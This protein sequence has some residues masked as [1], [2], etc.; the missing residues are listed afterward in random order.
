MERAADNMEKHENYKKQMGQLKKAMAS[1]FYLEAI[2]IEYAVIE[3]RIESVLRH[4]GK[5][6]PDK[7]KTL[8]KKLNRLSEMRR[9]KKSLANKYFPEELLDS[10]YNWKNDK[11]NPL[12]HALLKLHLDEDEKK[13]TAQQGE[14]LSKAF[15]DKA[16]LYN[17]ALDRQ[18]KKAAKG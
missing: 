3:D 5:F 14:M 4:S 18:N 6:N 8:D 7:H 13:A 1:G 15:R 17:R 2:S 11:R 9:E 10:L 16:N 12:T